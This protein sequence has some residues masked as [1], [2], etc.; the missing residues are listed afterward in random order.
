MVGCELFVEDFLILFSEIV[1]EQVHSRNEGLVEAHK[2]LERQLADYFTSLE[3][4]QRDEVIKKRKLLTEKRQEI[5]DEEAG[6][7][8]K[9]GQ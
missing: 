5:L 9:A 8:G 2:R 4:E 3:R 1:S 6:W 7:P